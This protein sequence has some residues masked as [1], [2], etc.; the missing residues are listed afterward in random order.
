MRRL[1]SLALA[2]ALVPA[3]ALAFTFESPFSDGCH[4]RIT[5]AA[6][7]RVGW[8]AGAHPPDLSSNDSLRIAHDLPFE[9]PAD[10]QNPWSLALLLGARDNDLRGYAADDFQELAEV[11]A[12][13]EDQREHCLRAPSDDGPDGDRTALLACRTFIVE[14]LTAAIGAA[15][16]IDLAATGAQTV[17][18]PFTGRRAVT[19]QRYGW[20]LGRALH[21]LQDSFAHTL[22]TPDGA[23]VRHVLNFVDRAQ[24]SGYDEA[25]DGHDHMSAL[26]GC[27]PAS[28]AEGHRTAVATEASEQLLRAVVEGAGG[29]PARVLRAAAVVDAWTV[30]EPGCSITNRYCDAPE[31]S[32][33]S[34]GCAAGPTAPAHSKGPALAALSVAA[35]LLRSRRRSLAALSLAAALALIPR[36]ALAQTPSPATPNEPGL[37]AV[38]A[39]VGASIDRG[40]MAASLGAHLRL[41]SRFS[42]G[43][44]AEYNPWY[45]LATMRVFTGVFNAYLTGSFAW[46]RVGNLVLH[47]SL[48]A[49]TSVLL[50]DL[51][52]ADSGSVGLYVGASILGMTVD[53]SRHVHL[54]VLPATVCVPIPQ[55]SGVPI[56]YQ[57]YRFSIGF[58]W[59]T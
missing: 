42:L 13:P 33:G 32:E 39:L 50:A 49:G 55:L 44:T 12:T 59:D 45:S 41:S 3:R 52:G 40:A 29:G 8:P 16:D 27:D 56:V 10:A 54:I 26:D 7:A 15:A 37:L 38:R 22:R 47:S 51:I 25:R 9:L 5:R 35:V 53:L 58:E 31:L 19:L 2:L 48:S 14:E 11:H 30:I 57:Q 36:G 34:A 23:R 20:H 24:G 28:L 1:D 18:L 21:A 4:E 43:L 17:T 6:L 46:R